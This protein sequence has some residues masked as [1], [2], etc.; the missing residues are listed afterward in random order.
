MVEEVNVQIPR[1]KLGTQGLE[2]SKL[3][4]GCMG[5]NGGYT[6][7]IAEDDA[8]SMIKYVFSKGITFFDTAD[9]YGANANEV[10]IGKVQNTKLQTISLHPL[11][12]FTYD[13]VSIRS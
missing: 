11:L 1:V 10:L 3:G 8:I 13:V 6:G 4:Y 2:V 5:L 9:V 12:T 7:P